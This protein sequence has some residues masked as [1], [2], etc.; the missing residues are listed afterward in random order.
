MNRREA[1]KCCCLGCSGYEYKE[2]RGCPHLDCPLYKYRTSKGKQDPIERD[3]AIRAYCMW[4]TLDQP[5]EISLCPSKFCSLY[6]FRGYNRP[7]KKPEFRKKTSP[8]RP[9]RHDL[10]EVIPEHHLRENNLTK[11]SM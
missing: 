6:S 5:R 4:C 1:I 9:R 2:G 8:G 3:R 11:R 7:K 10:P